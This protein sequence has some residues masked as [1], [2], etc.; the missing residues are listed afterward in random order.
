[1]LKAVGWWITSLADEDLPAPQELVGEL[2]WEVRRGLARYLDKGLHLVQCRGYSWCRFDCG[3]KDSRMGSWDMTDGTWVWPQGLAHYVEVHNVVLP[4]EFVSHALSGA[5]PVKPDPRQTYDFG[6]WT[7]WSSARRTPACRESLRVAASA[8]R[9]KITALFVER[10]SAVEREL[11]LS[12]NECVWRG[13]SRKALADKFVCAEHL[14]GGPGN[15]SAE[16]PLVAGLGEYLRTLAR[17][18]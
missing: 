12:S 3:V 16:A 10:I 2:P 6:Y 1:M 8:A 18:R 15:S 7:G 11:G 4:E 5:V 9:E 14:L 17:G 13:C